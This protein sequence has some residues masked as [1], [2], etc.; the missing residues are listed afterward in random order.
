[1][2][3]T[4]PWANDAGALVGHDAGASGCLNCGTPMQGPFCAECGQQARSPRPSTR[5][6]AADLYAELVGWDTKF[7]RTIRRL[8]TR[9][10]ELTRLF[11]EGRRASHIPPVRLYLMCGI[12]YF[13]LAAAAPPPPVEVADAGIGFGI[14]TDTP[15]P[16]EAAL[17]EAV[18]GGL[19]SLTAEERAALEAEIAAMPPFTRPIVRA[20]VEDYRALTERVADTMPRVL[21]VLL[22]A[23]A[24]ILG[25]FH[26]GRNYPEHLCFAVHFQSF[27]FLALSLTVLAQFGSSLALLTAAQAAAIVWIAVYA[28]IAQHRVYGG[29]WIATGTKAL[30]VAAVYGALW[31]ATVLGVTLWVSRGR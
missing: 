8:V 12:V 7:A 1:M 20:M 6:L 31:S 23:F 22:P 30:G 4:R 24:L 11:L 13:V 21:F 9:P 10:G 16:G 3:T 5:E 14:S 2:T 29:S 18:R 25:V 27:V 15:T 17:L 19:A 28:V 26:R